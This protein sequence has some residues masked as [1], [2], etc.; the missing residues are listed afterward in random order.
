MVETPV[1]KGSYNEP[2]RPQIHFTPAAHWMNDPNGMVFY[3][4]EYH[5]FY[6]YYPDS[7]VWG[8]M[9]WGHAISQDM[10][11]WEHLPVALYPDSLGYIFSGSAVVDWKNTSGFGVDGKPPLVAMFTYHDMAAEKAGKKN[12]QSQAIAYSNDKGRTWTKYAG[13]PVIPNPGN[14]KDIRDPKLIW[15]EPSKQWIVALAVGDHISFYC[16]PDFKKWTFLSDFGKTEGAHGGV[17]ECPDLF[18]IK[19]EGSDQQKWVLLVNINPGAPNG[20][21]GCQYFVGDFNGKKFVPE[22]GF[23]RDAAIEKGIWLDYGKDHYATVS[24]SDIPDSDGRRLCI[25]WM[26]NWEYA[27]KVPTETWRSA[28]TLPRSLKLYNMEKGYRL[29]VEPVVE[30]QKIRATSFDLPEIPVTGSISLTEKSVFLPCP[31]EWIFEFK[32]PETKAG[33]FGIELSNS[34]GEKYRIGYDIARNQFY[35]DRTEAGSNTFSKT[36]ASGVHVAQRISENGTVK[37]H[38]FFDNTSAELFADGGSVAMTEL[39]FP[40]HIFNQIHVFAGAETPIMVKAKG[41]ELKNI[42]G[43]TI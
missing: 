6:Q 23:I 3:E 39:F 43:A 4:G 16:S 20:G 30:L 32:L 22:A 25:G 36:F 41:W 37:M 17:W 28:N 35:S 12:Y 27:Q 31:S 18:P 15:H 5:L 42:W 38:L 29:R 11:R 8:P 9:H 21:S 26:S 14:I 7:S 13:N 24:W 10:V 33:N 40:N 2:Y 34:E 19:L 1:L